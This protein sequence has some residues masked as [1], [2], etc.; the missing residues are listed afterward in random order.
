VVL[1]GNTVLDA[2]SWRIM[3][4]EHWLVSGANGAGKTTLLRVIRG[5]QPIVYGSGRRTYSLLTDNDALSAAKAL[6][7]YLAPEFHE[8][9]LRMELPLTARELILGGLRGTLYLF[10]PPT[11]A[12]RERVA[13]LADMLELEPILDEPMMELSFGQLRRTL[14]ARALAIKPRVFVLDEF[15]HGIDRH[16]RRLIQGA[17]AQ[18]AVEGSSLVVATHRRE[19]LPA[20]ITHELQLEAGRVLRQGSLSHPPRRPAVLATR[21][22]SLGSNE[23]G[24]GALIVRMEGIEVYQDHRRI[25]QGIN[26]EIRE[27]EHWLVSGPN[28]AGKTTLAKLLFGRLRAAYG[29]TIE[30]YGSH[31]NL[32]IAELRRGVSLISD[33]EQLRYDWSIPVEAVIA[34]GFFGSVGLLQTPTAG[35]LQTVRGLLQDFG[36]EHLRRQKFLELSFGQ[37][38]LVLFARSLVR[39]PRLLI[40]DEALN[41]LDHDVRVRVFR[42]M[43]SLA[44]GGTSVV[45]IGHHD[46]DIPE[47]VENELCLEAGRISA[48]G[49]REL[50]H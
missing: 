37:R 18:A 36:I 34:S 45:I 1:A 35:Q 24:C 28:G 42:R 41:G 31:E 46:S 10:G 27:G 29:G 40:L 12:E 48:I 16:S 39:R 2:V 6:I 3:P 43:E 44:A 33:D 15:A 47:W 14:L 20:A 21:N 19:E 25:L 30:R 11:R 17:I 32:S 9:L 38:R 22:G 7:G 13:Q 49:R 5:D 23:D 50:H 26:W 8:R 4:G